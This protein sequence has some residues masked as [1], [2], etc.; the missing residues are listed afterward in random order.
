M[1]TYL[2]SGGIVPPIIDLSTRW[3]WMVSFKLRPLHPHGESPWWP[4]VHKI[5]SLD[6]I[7]SQTNPVQSV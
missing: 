5:R 1:K 2:G 4:Y 3:K 7:V 6:R